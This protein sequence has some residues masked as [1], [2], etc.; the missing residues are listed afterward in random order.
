M[1]KKTIETFI[2]KYSLNGVIESV[3]WVVDSKN[4]TLTTNA[5]TEEKN[6][7]I[8]VKMEDFTS[9]DEDIEIG[10]YETSKL[11]KMLSVLSDEM[12]ISINKKDDEIKSLGLSDTTTDVQFVTADLSVIPSS[13]AL[14][15]LPDFGVEIS[16]DEEFVNKFIKAKSALPEVDTFTLKMNKK[17]KLE[18]VIGYSELNSN[19]ITLSL[20]TADG[21][22]VV[23]KNISFNAKYL[24][25]ILTSNSDCP[26]AKL[27]V[28]D[29]GISKIEFSNDSFRSTYYMVEVKSAD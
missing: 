28:S 11:V 21:K 3:K 19:R 14:K 24:K 15:K 7:L 27:M 18:M 10:I 20:T 4:K 13:P 29:A 25:E 9:I 26:N 8:D 17:N 16:M 5:I 1:N 22:N 2:K 23:T 6:V 12:T